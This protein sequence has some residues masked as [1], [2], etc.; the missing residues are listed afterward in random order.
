MSSPIPI[1]A[2]A[3]ST[4]I[5]MCDFCARWNDRRLTSRPLV[6]AKL[7]ETM[8]IKCSPDPP[9]AYSTDDASGGVLVGHLDLD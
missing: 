5:H 2:V 4:G 9:L 3:V 7:R 6:C 1:Y 8:L